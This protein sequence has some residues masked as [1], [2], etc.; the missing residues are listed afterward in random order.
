MSISGDFS[1]REFAATLRHLKPGKA[2]DPNSICPE[3]YIH[4]SPD[5]KSWLLDF[6]SSC[7][8]RL[9][10]LKF[11]RRELVV[12]IPKLSKPEEDPKSYRR[13]FLFGIPYKTLERLI[14]NCVEPIV[15]PLLPKKQAGFRHGKSTV[16]QVVLLTQNVEN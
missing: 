14:Y 1:P 11:W 4:S 16:D 6:F 3:I 15:E 8:R 7:L 10:V 12:A 2:P 5:L 13:F 9:K